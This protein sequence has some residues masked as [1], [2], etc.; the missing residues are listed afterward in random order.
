MTTG[1][2]INLADYQTGELAARVVSLLAIPLSLRRVLFSALCVAGPLVVVTVVLFGL[3]G[4]S[5]W[6]WI[7]AT[8]YSLAAGLV[9][10]AAWAAAA[11]RDCG[12]PISSGSEVASLA[13][14]KEVPAPDAAPEA[15]SRMG[16]DASAALL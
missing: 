1:A 9:V 15:T 2:S 10:T 13:S 5:G 6:V 11:L 16:A 12:A 8:V 3:A 4:A 14:G 7:G